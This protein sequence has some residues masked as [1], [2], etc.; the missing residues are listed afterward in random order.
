MLFATETA[1]DLLD[2]AVP[3]IVSTIADTNGVLPR[4]MSE[5]L[6]TRDPSRRSP[7]E[8]VLRSFAHFQRVSA[9]EHAPARAASERAVRKEPGYA[10]AWAMMSLIYNEE[11][12]HRFNLLSDPLGRA[13][14]AAQRAMDPPRIIPRFTHWHPST[15]FARIGC[16]PHRD[17][18]RCC[19]ES[20]GWIH[21]C[22]PGLPDR[23]CR[24]LGTRRRSFGKSPQRES[25][26]PGLVLVCSVLRC[27]S[28]RRLQNFIGF[29]SQRKYAGILANS[30]GHRC[31]RRATRRP[32]HGC[33]VF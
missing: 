2:D 7:Y 18:A 32:G 29:R 3:R 12:T 13:L 11:Y 21:T 30:I 19:F 10:D 20:D 8:A 9:E 17:D 1:F 23:L 26:S 15:S 31:E 24:R 33:T 28:K 16:L 14:V 25:L 5:T 6:R 22:L 4:S 27:V